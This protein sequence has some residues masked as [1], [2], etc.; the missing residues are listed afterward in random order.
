MAILEA[1]GLGLAAGAI[2]TVA[3]TLAEKAEMRI[4]GREAST[5]PGQVGAKLA[6]RDPEA[7]PELVNRLNPIVHWAHG[8]S[9]EAVRGLLDV[10]GL[11]AVAA[12]AVFYGL[13]WGGD[14]LLYR[15]LGLAPMPW[16]WKR[17][18]LLTD[19]YGKGL[20]A[21]ATSVAYLLLDSAF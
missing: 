7:E 5:F 17:G 2:G 20:L 4:T 11:G 18:E 6:G 15:A 21:V 3:L 13:V 9:L 14:V 16:K 12:T 10:A 1:V 8:I 19:L